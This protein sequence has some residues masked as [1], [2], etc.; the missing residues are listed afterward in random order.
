MKKEAPAA[1]YPDQDLLDP[2]PIL[3]TKQSGCHRPNEHREL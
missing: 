3:S 2:A 1:R